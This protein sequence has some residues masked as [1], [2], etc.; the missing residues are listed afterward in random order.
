M[1][2][3]VLGFAL[4]KIS[5]ERFKGRLENVKVNTN[6]DIN[7]IEEVKQ[8]TFKLKESVIEAKFSFELDYSPEIAKISI[9]GNI[10]LALESNVSKE[11]LKMWKEK[12]IPEEF[13]INLFNLIFKKASIKAIE[14]ED[15]MNLPVHIPL[16]RIGT[17][18]EQ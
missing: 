5:I 12:Q 4:S 10:I 18:K 1:F 2:M 8:N 11:V 15:E 13:K 16:P 7:E 14:L 17:Q 6:I 9:A 3:K